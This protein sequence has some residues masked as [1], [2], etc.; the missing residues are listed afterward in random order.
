MRVIETHISFVLLTG[1][2]A[3]KI[4]KAVDLGFLDFRSLSSRSFYCEEELRLNRRTAPEIYLDVVTITGSVD[5][6]ALGGHGPP[7]E[8]ALKMREFPQEALALHALA[9]GALSPTVVDALAQQVADLHGAARA[10]C[11][12][13]SRGDPDVILRLALRTFER[14]RADPGDVGRLDRLRAWTRAEHAAV[15][16]IM[17]DR[18][19]RGR[20]RECHGDLHLGNIAAIDGKPVVFDCLEFSEEL[21]WTDVMSDV[22]FLVMDFRRHCR[23]DLAQRFLNAYLEFTGDYD[24]LRVLRFYFVYRAMVRAMV[25]GERARQLGRG[26]A[27]NAARAESRDYLDVAGRFARE[28]QPAILITHGFSGCG[29]TTASQSLFEALAGVRI[30]T[31]VERKR[32]H[33]LRPTDREPRADNA[34]LY[35]SGVTRRVYQRVLA[36]TRA[37]VEAGFPVVVDGAFLWR[38][39]REMFRDLARELGMPFLV[40]GFEASEATLRERIARRMRDANDASDADLAVL[41]QQ[42]RSAQPL[43][44]DE[45]AETIVI[46]AEKPVSSAQWLTVGERLERQRAARGVVAQ[47]RASATSTA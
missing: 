47:Q 1:R 10:A 33:G 13:G 31:D 39:Q 43:E 30:R 2:C 18:C 34:A 37:S 28:R 23:R 44:A 8:Y 22:A 38:W 20:I 4:K 36:L 24:G 45:Q 11:P 25:A 42:L 17:R 5:A 7:I 19:G 9:R 6:P 21:R 32:L 35:S 41:D 3:Y 15:A 12:G 40:V 14:M 16:A 29:K 26:A 27:G 46:D